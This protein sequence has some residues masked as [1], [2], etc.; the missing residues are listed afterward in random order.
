MH[1]V[2]SDVRVVKAVLFY[3]FFYFVKKNFKQAV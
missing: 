3:Y 1:H 2:S